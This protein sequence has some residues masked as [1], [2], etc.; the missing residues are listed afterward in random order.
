MGYAFPSPFLGSRL[1]GAAVTRALR[2]DWAR[3][4][5]DRGTLSPRFHESQAATLT[6]IAG[7]VFGALPF[8]WPHRWPPTFAVP[9]LGIALHG[10]RVRK[11]DLVVRSVL[12]FRRPLPCPTT[13]GKYTHSRKN[14]RKKFTLRPQVIHRRAQ[15][16]NWQV[17]SWCINRW[18]I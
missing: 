14:P 7:G 6:R 8:G 9:A 5:E 15:L 11:S 3:F 13:D 1:R 16:L 4:V 18:I 2:A 17:K 12:L 10:L